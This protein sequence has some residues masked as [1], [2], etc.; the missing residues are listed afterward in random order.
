MAKGVRAVPSAE[1]PV[2]SGRGGE[3]NRKVLTAADAE[4]ELLTAKDEKNDREG[5]KERKNLKP[6]STQRRAAEVAEKGKPKNRD[7]VLIKVTDCSRVRTTQSIRAQ[8][9]ARHMSMA[10]F[11]GCGGARGQREVGQNAAG[12]YRIRCGVRMA[13]VRA[14]LGCT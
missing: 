3:W 5:R 14:L 2:S 10:A 13:S 7:S 8:Q 4:K 11:T 12:A 1:L 6:Q 9:G